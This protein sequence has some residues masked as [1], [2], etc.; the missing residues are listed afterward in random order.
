M[1]EPG[2]PIVDAIMA[3][4][5]I[6]AG[7]IVDAAIIAPTIKGSK[8]VAPSSS[9]ARKMPREIAFQS[10]AATPTSFAAKWA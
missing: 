7:I 2:A 6:A 5:A 10:G 8:G 3:I 9:H 1:A 4:V